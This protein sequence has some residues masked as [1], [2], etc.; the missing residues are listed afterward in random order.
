MSDL[1]SPSG[2]LDRAYERIRRIL[3]EARNRAYQAINSA[4][5]STHRSAS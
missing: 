3:A 5:V 1:V 4:L 2:N